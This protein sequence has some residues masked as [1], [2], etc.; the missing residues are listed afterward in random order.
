MQAS[1]AALA[2][3]RAG[4]GSVIALVGEAGIGKTRLCKELVAAAEHRGLRVTVGRSSLEYS[5][6]PLRSWSEALM[7][8]TRGD[9]WP[10][11]AAA[12]APYRAALG[13]VVPHWREPNWSAPIE[14][15]VV[16]GEAILRALAHLAGEDGMLVV[17]DDLHW[18]DEQTLASLTYV[19]DHIREVSIV[20]CLS[21]RA[22]GK[23]VR[24]LSELRRAD[25]SEFSLSRLT[26][27]EVGEMIDRCSPPG[28]QSIDIGSIVNDSEGLP[29]VIEDLLSIDNSGDRPRRF[30]DVV[31]AHLEALPA[32]HRKAIQAAALLGEKVEWNVVAHALS[33][34]AESS[35]ASLRNATT[36]DLLATDGARVGF[37]HALTRSVVIADIVSTERG[38]LSRALAEALCEVGTPGLERDVLAADL[39]LEAAAPELA[40]AILDKARSRAEAA[41][42][43]GDA[44]FTSGRS[45]RLTRDHNLPGLLES[46]LSVIRSNLLVGNSAAAV[47][48]ATDLLARSDGANQATTLQ[49]HL[50]LARA[51][52]GQG[53][54]SFAD[55]HLAAAHR[56]ANT[57]EAMAELSL[58]DAESA[59]GADRPGQRVSVEHQVEKAVAM[60]ERSGVDRVACDVYHFAGRV[61]RQRDLNDAAI[62]LEKALVVAERAQL[63]AQRLSVLN[64]LGTVEMLRDAR[65]DRLERAYSEALRVGAFGAAVSAGLNLASACVMTG[66]HRRC[67]DLAAE[68]QAI[69]ARVGLRNL[70]AACEF[71]LGIAAAFSADRTTAERHCARA[72]LLAPE[73]GDLRAGVWAIAHGVGA[74]VDDD[75]PRARRAFA[76]ARSH[77]PE[78]HA[79]ILDASLG[80]AMLL[81]AVDALVTSTQVREALNSEVRGA[82]WS[83]LWLGA[84]LAV[85]LANEGSNEQAAIELAG[86][87]AAGSRYP[88]FGAIVRRVVAAT[89]AATV[90]SRAQL[91]RDAEVAF[92][93][94]GLPRAAEN[95]RGLLRSLGHAAPRQRGTEAILDEDLRRAG[96]TA[97]EAEVLDFL[98]DRQTNREIAA[99]LFVSPKTVEKH[100]AA[101]IV[102]LGAANRV[103]LAEIARR[104]QAP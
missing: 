21:L 89:S 42:E 61:A 102:K 13:M 32:Q 15:P 8:A 57:D 50:L 88:L 87:L 19:V 23:G 79:R 36:E 16:L 38:N 84:A 77:A 14:A 94:L 54:W 48:L 99:Q 81:D 67:A 27:S 25:V 100:V 86:A 103:E 46:G 74:L 62:A 34:D 91:L 92:V 80:P 11:D 45:F 68:V 60:A 78:R 18:A 51:Y 24:T 10:T 76:T 3:A 41:G 29:L 37:R 63:S 55:T 20:L 6:V 12:L 70:E 93:A 90:N 101:L 82:R 65:T 44:A 47:D 39:M 7:A 35:V 73:D 56:L 2:Q 9:P 58:L 104:R 53:E 17:L 96:V 97:R 22:E 1:D 98:R 52:V 33:L 5:G 69:A 83:E 43:L 85:A 28:S 4:R 64:E 66:H 71:H 26:P 49:L 40:V 72:E 75:R 31:H 95:A 59:F 30:A